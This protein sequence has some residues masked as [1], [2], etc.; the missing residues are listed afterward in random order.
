MAA[1]RLPTRCRVPQAP[2]IIFHAAPPRKKISLEEL[3]ESPESERGE[4]GG[5][6]ALPEGSHLPTG[7]SGVREVMGGSPN[8]DPSPGCGK[9]MRT[10]IWG[11]CSCWVPPQTAPKTPILPQTL[12]L[13]AA[14]VGLP[15]LP[16]QEQQEFNGNNKKTP[17]SSAPAEGRD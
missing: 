13:R 14:F 1:W 5:K 3:S 11:C 6:E 17:E 12:G 4:K 2:R 15:S 16:W 7:W 9:R 10:R 8:W